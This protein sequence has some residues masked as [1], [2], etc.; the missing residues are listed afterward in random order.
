MKIVVVA[1]A[2]LF[3]AG[4]G[5]DDGPKNR[6]PTIS[7]TSPVAVNKGVTTVADVSVGDADVR[8]ALTVTLGG[9][10]ATQFS[11]S[12]SNQRLFSTAPTHITP[13][14]AN[15]DNAYELTL[16][17]ADGKGGTASADLTV[18]VIKL[19]TGRVVDPRL[20]GSTVFID[21]DSNLVQDSNEA[22]VLSDAEGNFE[23]PDTTAA[24]Q[25]AGV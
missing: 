18:N 16:N 22:S 2:L 11:I 20:S 5:G 23:I 24:C 15:G 21:L 6:I 14:D 3:L 1:L 17:V 8:D 12:A 4:C 10:D 13:V 7:V 25:G 9:T 19:L